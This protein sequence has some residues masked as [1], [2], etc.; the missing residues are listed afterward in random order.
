MEEK[1]LIILT[2]YVNVGSSSPE[3]AKRIMERTVEMVLSEDTDPLYR[4]KHF[5]YPV[6]DEVNARTECIYPVRQ[7]PMGIPGVPGDYFESI[8]K[9]LDN[10]YEQLLEKIG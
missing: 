7:G 10:K 1:E 2:H 9:D 4:F 8:L 3:T 6:K 5:F